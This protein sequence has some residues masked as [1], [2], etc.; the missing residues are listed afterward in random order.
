MGV[1]L[2]ISLTSFSE[3]GT[4]GLHCYPSWDVTV[5]TI[6]DRPCGKGP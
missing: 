5:L 4:T 3:N 2:G 6:C 1:E